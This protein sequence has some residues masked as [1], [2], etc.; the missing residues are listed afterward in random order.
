MFTHGHDDHIGAAP[1]LLGHF[2]PF[3]LYGSPLTAA[4]ATQRLKDGGVDWPVTVVHNSD[5]H[6]LS[7]NF[8]F[9][10][11]NMT[12]SVPDTRHIGIM[13]P[14]GTYYHGSDF[15]L[16]DTPVDGVKPAYDEIKQFATEHPVDTMLIDCL[17]VEKQE[18]VPSEATV[19]PVI[20]RLMEQTQGKC[21]MTLMSSH[22]HRIQH[23]VNAAKKFGRKVVFV[24]RSVEQNVK[25]ALELKELHIENEQIVDKKHIG[26]HPDNK[27]CVII[28]GSQGQEGS[29]LVRAVFGDH[30]MIQIKQND[31]VIFSADAIPGNEI[32]YYAA[33]DELSRNGVHVIYPDVEPGIHQSGHASAPEQRKLVELIKPKLVMPIG[34][35]DR[36]REK[37]VEYVGEPLG[38]DRN[39]IVIP[40]NGDVIGLSEGGRA[41][42]IDS[43]QIKPQAVDGLGIGDVGPVVLADRRALSEAGMIVVIIPRSGEE[44]LLDKIQVVSRGFVFMQE[45]DEVVQFIISETQKILR[46]NEEHQEQAVIRTLS[47][48]LG[49][50][51]HKAIRREPVIMPVFVDC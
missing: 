46:S 19:G 32:P 15:K 11:F 14:A 23:T 4:F 28:A 8:T 44:V 35:A 7:D 24:G 45:A 10:M 39:H 48:R 34:G 26:D 2:E 13:T 17:R 41:E 47:K 5:E 25:A 51:L 30:P 1:Y 38:Y 21:I 12:H 16:D 50:K 33:I 3:P 43:V 20:E 18:V 37:F 31:M 9:K 22:I 36:H 6:K 40:D 27:L 42:V 49:R 29:S